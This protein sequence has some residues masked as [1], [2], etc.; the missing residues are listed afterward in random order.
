MCTSNTTRAVGKANKPRYATGNMTM[1]SL[2][3]DNPDGVLI[4]Q[5]PVKRHDVRAAKLAQQFRVK[6]YLHGASHL[7]CTRCTAFINARSERAVLVAFVAAHEDCMGSV[8]GN[9]HAS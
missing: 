9:E 4:R 5:L 6:T 2:D 8:E 7:I 3:L 1:L